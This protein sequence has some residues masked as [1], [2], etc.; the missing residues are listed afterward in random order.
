MSP[1]PPPQLSKS[2]SRQYVNVSSYLLMHSTR[3][4]TNN[5]VAKTKNKKHHIAIHKSKRVVCMKIKHG[6]F[7]SPATQLK[8]PR[9]FTKEEKSGIKQVVFHLIKKSALVAGGN[10]LETIGNSEIILLISAMF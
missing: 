4:K 2:M 3:F 6:L 8:R 5:L 9:I 7:H 10:P 1:P